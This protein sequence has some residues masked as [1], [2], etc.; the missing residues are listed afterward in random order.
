METDANLTMIRIY[1]L[2][3]ERELGEKLFA[4]PITGNSNDIVPMPSGT[5]CLLYPN[6]SIYKFLGAK[7]LRD[8]SVMSYLNALQKKRLA[9]DN[10]K[11]YIL[12][13]YLIDKKLDAFAHT[14][15]I[16]Y[17]IDDKLPR[18]YKE[19][20]I[21][22]RHL[23]ANPFV[24]YHNDVMDTDYNDLQEL[25]KRHNTQK[26]RKDAVYAQYHDTY[27]WYYEYGGNKQE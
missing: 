23:R 5:G 17:A 12:C 2:A 27:W 18:Y 11:D 1:A 22:Y 10:V 14:L 4:Y 26:V 13:G 20:L 6:D 24:V 21:L 15:P 16:F 3:K 19:A 25:E 9:S 8:M 7:P